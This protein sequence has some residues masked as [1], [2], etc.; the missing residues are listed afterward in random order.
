MWGGGLGVTASAMYST[1]LRTVCNLRTYVTKV[2]N[3]LVA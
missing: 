3:P 1:A 2:S